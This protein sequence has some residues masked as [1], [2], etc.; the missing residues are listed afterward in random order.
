MTVY[1]KPE[2]VQAVQ[3]LGD[4]LPALMALPQA[5]ACLWWDRNEI[6]QEILFIVQRGFLKPVIKNDWVVVRPDFQFEVYSPDEM[7]KRFVFT[8][9]EE[10]PEPIIQREEL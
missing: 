2:E 6:G 3:W 5:K 4:N 7:E 1:T 8:G 9:S 10:I